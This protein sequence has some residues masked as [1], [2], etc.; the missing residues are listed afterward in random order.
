MSVFKQQYSDT[1]LNACPLSYPSLK[2]N[3]KREYVSI[4][5]GS[6]CDE[7]VPNLSQVRLHILCIFAPSMF[8][9]PSMVVT[10]AMVS[11][12]LSR[13]PRVGALTGLKGPRS[14]SDDRSPTA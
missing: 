6:S 12:A 5:V 9:M 14:V 2:C 1:S 8:K 10:I 7:V 4:Y 11:L 13:V 3:F